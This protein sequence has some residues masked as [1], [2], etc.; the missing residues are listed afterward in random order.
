[1]VALSRAGLNALGLVAACWGAVGC[2]PRG[3]APAGRRLLADGTAYAVQFVP[4]PLGSPARLATVEITSDDGSGPFSIYAVQEPAGGEGL[5]SETFLI[6][7]VSTQSAGCAGPQCAPQTDSQGR[8]FVQRTR[9]M[10]PDGQGFTTLDNSLARLDL[11]SGQAVDFGSGSKLVGTFASGAAF[12]YTIGT[13]LRIRDADDHETQFERVTKA[14]VVNDV[15]YFLTQDQAMGQGTLR[16]LSAPPFEMP[17]SVTDRLTA[18]STFPP[19]P[20]LLVCRVLPGDSSCTSSV[21][22][23]ATGEETAAP[24][25]AGVWSIAPSGRYLLTVRYPTAIEIDGTNATLSLFDRVLGAEQSLTVTQLDA[26]FW[27]PG[28]DELWFLA[29]P[30]GSDEGPIAPEAPRPTL[31][32]WV[33]GA[34]PSPVLP[35]Q[36]RYIAGPTDNPHWPFT[37]DGRFLIT[38]P[39]PQNSDAPPVVVRDADNPTVPLLT[40]NPAGTAVADIRQLPDGRLVVSDALADPSRGDIYVVDPLAG[41]MQAIAHGGK[42]EATGDSRVLALLDWED[43]GS[44][45]ALSLID[46]ATG[47]TTALAQVVHAVTVDSPAAGGDRLGPGTRIAYLSQNRVSSPYDGLWLTSLP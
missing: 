29:T 7:H 19:A 10:T 20:L 28:R 12:A 33:A 24:T 26:T 16:R 5:G 11:A 22:N 37:P 15:L 13:S 27:R 43:G 34:D 44:S 32:R 8:M 41:T 39:A 35:D 25:D 31:W 23:V 9:S 17:Q 21:L 30:A 36:G 18:F 42:V 4:G 38:T 1:V 3:P 45:G 47:T 14:A 6:D 40:L 46:L 2:L